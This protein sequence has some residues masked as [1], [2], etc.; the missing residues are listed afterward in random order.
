[1]N[2]DLAALRYFRLSN[3]A[4]PVSG[5]EIARGKRLIDILNHPNLGALAATR[6]YVAAELD[7]PGSTQDGIV[8]DSH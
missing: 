6:G 8:V 1:M 3:S 5:L 7:Y 2:R 4:G